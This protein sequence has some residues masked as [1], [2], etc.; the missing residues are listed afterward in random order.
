MCVRGEG[1]CTCGLGVRGHVYT[2]VRGEESCTCVLGV[3]GHV[4]VC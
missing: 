1:S 3:R 2:C 4:H